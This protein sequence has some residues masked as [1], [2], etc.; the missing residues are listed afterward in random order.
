MPIQSTN[1]SANVLEKMQL[2][3][4]KSLGRAGMTQEDCKK[5][6]LGKM[7]KELHAEVMQFINLRGGRFLRARMDRKSRL[8]I[9]WPDLT[10][11]F[12]KGLTVFWEL[13]VNT[14]TLDY[15]QAEWQEVLAKLGHHH[16]VIC[17]LDDCRRHLREIEN[18]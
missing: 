5:A 18:L 1:L 14:Y 15:Q 9:G 11:F 12:P 2:K 8:P 3:D 10:V 16:R 4:R 6:A 7:E 13:K 17:H